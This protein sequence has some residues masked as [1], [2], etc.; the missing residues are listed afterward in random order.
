MALRS[1]PAAGTP[2]GDGTEPPFARVLCGIDGSPAADEA[3]R[4][5]AVLARGGSVEL[6][7]V[8]WT[9]GAGPTRMTALSDTRARHAL[10]SATALAAEQQARVSAD[11]VHSADAAGTLLRRAADHDL[12]VV[13]ARIGSR[14]GGIML[15]SLASRVVHT[16]KVPVLV[17]RRPPEG[18]AFPDPILLAT[19]GSGSSSRAATLAGR[20]A[21]RLGSE[22]LM[23]RVGTD[24]SAE[25]RRQVARQT[26][27]IMDVIGREPVVIELDHHPH[28][29]IVEV[30]RSERVSLIVLGSSGRRGVRALA[31]TS[32][33][34][35]HEAPCSVL[36]ARA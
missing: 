26:T 31:S 20:I 36:V 25:E 19:D 33:R 21:R 10:E 13:G 16:A 24:A 7:S 5:A 3:A 34:V 12:M 30:A 2:A 35:A 22:V 28:E 18:S 32:E 17:A 27:D 6:V 8:T 4:Q 1:Q 23:L 14:A 15:G 11:L 9:T 29:T